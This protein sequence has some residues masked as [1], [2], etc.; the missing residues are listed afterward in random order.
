M[1]FR[2]NPFRIIVRANMPRTEIR[3]FD[4]E[5]NAFIM[6]V[7]AHPEKGRANMEIIKFF[8]KKFKINVRIIS[9]IRSKEKL[10]KY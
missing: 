5:K 9:G 3:G 1:E 10:I 8:R 2:Q 4:K 7:H 6:D